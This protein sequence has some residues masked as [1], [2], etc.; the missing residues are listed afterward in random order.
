MNDD[1]LNGLDPI[2]P[3]NLFLLH[4]IK[5]INLMQLFQFHLFLLI[6]SQLLDPLLLL[7]LTDFSLDRVESLLL[8]DGLMMDNI[9]V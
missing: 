8:S 9:L 1:F 4:I 2:Q 6:L 3:F 5:G 7:P